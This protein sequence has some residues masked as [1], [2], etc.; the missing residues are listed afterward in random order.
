MGLSNNRIV[1]YPAD[2]YNQFRL[3]FEWYDNIS[4][5]RA[6][7]FAWN[8]MASLMWNS[9]TAKSKFQ[10]VD[11]LVV[12]TTDILTTLNN[13]ADASALQSISLTP[14]PT[15]ATGATEAQGIRGL[16]GAT[17]A[18]G[19][20]GI[21][22]L[23]GAAGAK[24]A[25]GATGAAGA[26]G[27]QGL[28]GATGAHG[29]QGLS[30]ARGATGATGP[31]GPQGIQGL[32]GATGPT[33]PA[34]DKSLYALKASSALTG[35]DTADN[36]TVSGNLLCGATNIITALGTKAPLASPTFTGTVAATA[37]NIT[38]DLSYGTFTCQSI[39]G[40]VINQL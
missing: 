10:I 28:T 31:T 3:N 25:T 23:T 34:P 38:T 37:A 1:A 26:Q 30:G 39:Y 35:T 4:N 12:G 40:G 21:Q 33:G 9:T 36:L 17:G 6:P 2:A 29:I 13:K 22:G 11:S 8:N 7:N 14:G 27:I 16:T 5:G 15:G 20:Q 19:A 18:A 24:G 32:T